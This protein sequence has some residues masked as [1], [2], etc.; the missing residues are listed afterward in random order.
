MMEINGVVNQA[1]KALPAETYVVKE[2]AAC[3]IGTQAYQLMLDF[4][5]TN[6]SL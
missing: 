1:A 4:F 2:E 5:K 3:A 6:S